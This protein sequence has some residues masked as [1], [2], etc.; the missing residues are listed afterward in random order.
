MYK[1]RPFDVSNLQL[2]YE[3]ANLKYG[4]QVH[5][6]SADRAT[7]TSR[8][9]AWHLKHTEPKSLRNGPHGMPPSATNPTRGNKIHMTLRSFLRSNPQASFIRKIQGERTG[10]DPH[11]HCLSETSA[12]EDNK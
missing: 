4:I 12:K 11:Y 6:D 5:S 9:L 1:T 7:T 10:D 2:T 3:I 8:E